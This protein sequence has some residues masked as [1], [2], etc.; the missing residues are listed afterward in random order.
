M[1][2]KKRTLFKIFIIIA[3]ALAA[4]FVSAWFFASRQLSHLET[5]KTSLTAALSEALNRDVTYET[6]RATLTLRKG[7]ALQFTNVVIREKD[8]S[9]D[10]L[11]VQTA[12][13]RVDLLPLLINRV[14]L[15]E[16]VLD[17]PR[18]SLKR[19]RA[20]ELNIADLLKMDEKQKMAVTFKRITVEKG[21]LTFS[22][23]AT[24]DKELKTSISNISCRIHKSRFSSKSSFHITAAVHEDKNQG[25][26]TLDG[27]YRPAPSERPVSE[28][29]VEASIHLKGTDLRHYL[30]YL[31][32]HAQIE[33][34]AGRLDTEAT[35]SGTLLSFM[36]KGT[37]S[38]K[39]ARLHYPQVFH[40]PVKSQAVHVQ[41]TLTR[42]AGDLR[43][44]VTRLALD[45]LEATGSFA[46][47]GMDREDPLLT[48]TAA[49]SI[50]SLKKIHSYVPWKIIPGGVG[51]FIEEHIP[52]GD[53]R[54]IE[55]KLDGRLSQI[56]NIN[57]P[58]NA[59]VLSIRAQVNKGIFFI[60]KTTPVFQ[61]LA[62]NLELINRQFM[63]KNVKGLFGASPCSVEGG[64][65][66]F[67]LPT[68]T[69]FT[70]E[71]TLQPAR[72]EILWLLG[73]EQFHDFR[74]TGISTLHLSGKGPAESYRIGARWDLMNA[75]YAF[76]EIMEKPKGRSNTLECE[77]ILNK[78]HLT[79][80]S[81]HY[82]LPPIGIH[83][84]AEDLFAAK[85]SVSLSVKSRAFDLREVS[86]LLPDL[87]AVDPK[88]T[89]E[90]DIA[91]LGNLGD[92]ASFRWKGNMSLS[93]V[94]MKPPGNVRQMKGLTGKATFL[95]SRMETSL[96]KTSVGDSPI[97]AKCG[98]DNFQ[99]PK[100]ACQ[101]D[102]PLLKTADLGLQ[103]PEGEINFQNVKGKISFEDKY[104]HVDRLSFRYAKS[105]FRL[106]GD[107]RDYANPKITASLTS[108]YIDWDD[109]A[110][111]M[112]LK[113]PKRTSG[114][115]SEVE[116]HAAA[117][118]DAFTFHGIDF[119]KLNTRLA[120]AGGILNIENLEAGLF[121]GSL[122]AKGRVDT[123]PDGQNRYQ[124]SLSLD[125]V[126]LDRLQGFLELEDRTVTGRLSL[127]GIVTATGNNEDDLKKT[128]AG[129]IQFKAE[130]GV[131]KK[132]SVLSKIFSLLNVSQLFKFQLPDMARGGMPYKNITADVNIKNGVLTSD[133]FF[134]DSD[135]MQIS[136]VGKIDF[137]GKMLD[138]TVGV[139]PLQT[140]DKIVSKIP[141]A[142]WLVTN[143]KGNLITVH[144]K[145]EGTWDNPDVKAIPVQ[146]ITKGT[147]DVFRRLFQLPEKL[148]TDT[149]EVILG[150]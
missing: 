64:I 71:M 129:S 90:I 98:I 63:L 89:C 116:L 9:S 17:S 137:V 55:G 45:H 128:A 122:K 49:T 60:G 79:V 117:Q 26:L 10:L 65:S 39:N 76:P 125:R 130:K 131:L 50:F 110:R 15:G 29:K 127:S 118:V 40:G 91:G 16:V 42:N 107:V 144:F 126:S 22:D 31:K 34:L 82:D 38:V 97:Q 149:G 46:L 114:S 51:E 33:D 119:N 124:A 23:Q 20:G 148:V 141:I 54:L 18:L 145:V 3:L 70:A 104:L 77:I 120:Y 146:S 132:F 21:L 113:D 85:K 87:R 5:Y 80:P 112:T 12:W 109:V 106:S 68:P 66:D 96:F 57:L 59:G 67:S 140:V 74:F 25:E 73:N 115:S 135:A 81:F 1:A 41:G 47:S 83:G 142:G 14:T 84:S 37:V 35:L 13:A 28:G 86:P 99:K 36:V 102:C 56:K 147:L 62:G 2:I 24:A 6:G 134:I 139:H 108:P 53:F 103:S 101:F 123:L 100:V 43:L 58:E 48:T 105:R 75:S 121:E 72:S 133:N 44:D 88:G 7:L 61:D 19:N 150:H 52:D 30:P 69:V 143:E 4:L 93:N 92:P 78:D 95:G 11:N 136:A 138:N 27:I 8:R 32:P 111:L 94:T